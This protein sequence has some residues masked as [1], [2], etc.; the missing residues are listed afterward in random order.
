MTDILEATTE[1]EMLGITDLL[2]D[3]WF[4]VETI[5]AMSELGSMSIEFPAVERRN[6]L[7]RGLGVTNSVD[8]I[9]LTIHGVTRWVLDDSQGIRFYPLNELRYDPHRGTVS[10]VSDIPLRPEFEVDLLHLK[11]RMACLP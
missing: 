7:R 10:L 11:A 2:H 4:D 6:A 9:V 3:R 8:P 1:A 5:S